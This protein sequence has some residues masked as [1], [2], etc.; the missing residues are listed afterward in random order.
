[1]VVR[2]VCVMWCD[3]EGW[4]KAKCGAGRDAKGSGGVVSG[5]DG[6]CTPP[7]SLSYSALT[8]TEERLGSASSK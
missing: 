1:M 8:R 4:G 2:G 7:V 3:E 6:P 5:R